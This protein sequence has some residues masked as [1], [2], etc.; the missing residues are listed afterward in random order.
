MGAYG[1]V[2]ERALRSLAIGNRSISLFY[3]I[4]LSIKWFRLI[5]ESASAPSP[6]INHMHMTGNALPALILR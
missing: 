3:R 5:G 4:F 1:L 2:L 6:S